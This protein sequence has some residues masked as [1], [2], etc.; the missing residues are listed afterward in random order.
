[1]A[2]ADQYSEDI[3]R[4]GQIGQAVYALPFVASPAVLAIA[5]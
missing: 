1:M 3:R 5:V 2:E 4:A